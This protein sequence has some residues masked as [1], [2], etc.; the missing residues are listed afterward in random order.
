MPPSPSS[1]TETPLLSL[2]DVEKRYGEKRVLQV[3]ALE[4]RRE[5]RMLI[6]GG[7]GRGK[8]TLLRILAG[9]APT[10][11]G[12]TTVSPAWDAMRVCYVPQA[13]GLYQNLTLTENVATL[14]RLL[15]ADI[16]K[17]LAGCWYIRELALERY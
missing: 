7:N 17:D 13:G 12:S 9:I 15:G 8:S 4:L 14:S 2:K 3:S 10:S 1:D 11:S 16:P 5:D 6:V